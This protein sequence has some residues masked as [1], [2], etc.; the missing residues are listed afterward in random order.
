MQKK[1]IIAISG[2][3]GAIYGIRM[4]EVLKSL[5]SVETHTIISNAAEKTI[6]LETDHSVE[7]VVRLADKCYA[8]DDIA[9][10]ISSGS[11]ITS[12]MVVVPCSIKT[13]SGIVNSYNDNLLIRAA[14]ATL[15]EGRK[16]VICPRETPLH[17]GHLRLLTQYIDMGG[18]VLPP[19]PAFYHSPKTISD[20]I[21]QTIGKILD[22]FQIE[23]SLFKRWT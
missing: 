2:A 12:G 16:L 21:D 23:H 22:Q 6:R 17:K 5:P 14:D 4:L 19:F 20:I 11:F 18:I 1:L 8:H 9:A 10:A 3:S 13:L 7:S 15:K